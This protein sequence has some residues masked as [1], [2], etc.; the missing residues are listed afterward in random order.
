M[1]TVKFYTLGCKVNQ[2]DT[3][4]LREQLGKRGFLELAGK[5]CAD[6]YV[7]NTCTVTQRADS[8]SLSLIRKAKG[9]NKRAKIIV[10]G[11]LAE[12]DTDR[13]KEQK[14]ASLIIKNK[15]KGTI[16]NLALSKFKIKNLNSKE[17]DDGRG[18]AYFNGHTR[19]FLKIQDGCDNFCSYCKVPLVRGPLK[20]KPL[21]DI[22]TEAKALAQNG[23]KEIVLTGIC[24]GS[25]GRDIKKR[26]T[27][28]DVIKEL[29]NIPALSRLRFSSIE[30]ADI[31][32]ALIKKI[33]ESKKVCRH[34]H[35]P[36]QSGDNDILKRMNRRYSREDY[37]ALIS[38]L[39]RSMP[40]IAI[41][42]DVLVG[43]PGETEAHFRN[44]V[45]LIK[46][47]K[48]LKVH[49]FPYS[50]REGTRASFF[51]DGIVDSAIIK[52]RSQALEKINKLISKEYIRLFK[53]KTMNVLF[54]N[55][56]KN[57]PYIWT[58]YTDNYIKVHLES[59][60][61]LK[62]KMVRVKLKKV[63]GNFMNADFN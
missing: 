12:L 36:I 55:N 9:E 44:T 6:L 34:L 23:F 4:L 7:I 18:I 54:E 41:T 46:K 26:V 53:G 13:I 47:I 17:K 11:C 62:N 22:I 27:L 31:T 14:A 33:S 50:R 61:S 19:A 52:K 16:R 25:Y 15:D 49:I 5:G 30:A 57:N 45:N 48:P 60:D 21:K 8:E 29:E 59:K 37:I 56:L 28:V 1:K 24:L 58:G 40:K 20:S 43:F 2:Y 63:C 35:I 32:D 3:Q 42:T 38:R 39:R 10:T 51:T